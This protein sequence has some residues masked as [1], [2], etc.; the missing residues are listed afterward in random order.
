MDYPIT[1]NEP[2]RVKAVRSYAAFGSLSEPAYDDLTDLAAQ[3][4]ASPIAF[5]NIIDEAKGW[6]KAKHGLPS[7]LTDVPR[8]AVCCAHAICRSDI[9]IV[10]DLSADIRFKDLPF[11]GSDPFLKFYA[12]MPL[13]NSAPTRA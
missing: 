11:I 13:I 4:T 5:V 9:L 1:D 8:G 10:P 7:E 12:G 2:E 3:I 6:L